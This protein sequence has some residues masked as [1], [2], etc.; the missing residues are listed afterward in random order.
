MGKYDMRIVKMKLADCVSP[1]YN[2]RQISDIEFEKLKHSIRTFGYND[3]IIVNQRN[4]HIVAGNQRHKALTELNKEN[5]GKYTIIDVVLVDL[6]PNDEKTFNIGHNKIG[7]EFDGEKLEQLLRELEGQ[8]CDMSLTGFADDIEDVDLEEIAD[9]ID[10]DLTDIGDPVYTI[11][12]KCVN[13]TQQD[14]LFERLKHEG[15]NVKAMKY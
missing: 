4:N 6:P 8:N 13:A 1:D 15:Y 7:G 10:C 12:V 5:H 2:P 3:P 9:E 11:N 14:M